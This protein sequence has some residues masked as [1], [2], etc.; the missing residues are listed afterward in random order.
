MPILYLAKVNLNSDIF[1]VYKKKLDIHTVMDLV[2]EKISN[3]HD[4][5]RYTNERY[6]DSLG[7]NIRYIR[8]SKYSFQEIDKKDH[9]IITGKIVRTFNRKTEKLNI[10]TQKMQNIDVI[11]NVSIY[12]YY[13]VY[14]EM[15]SFCERQTFGYNQFIEGFTELLNQCV[16]IYQFKIFLQKDK[17]VLEEKIKSL[18]TVYKVRAVLIPPNSNEEGLANLRGHLKYIS[19]IQDVNANKMLLEYNSLNMK[20]DS[21]IMNEIFEA[22]SIGYGDVTATGIDQDGHTQ[23]IR[24]SQDAAFTS[25]IEENIKEND[26]NREAKNLIQRFFEKRKHKAG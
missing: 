22:A 21:E 3:Q 26:Y 17:D 9:K 23:M 20:M 4:Y 1:D 18:K 12:F 14:N 16:G 2:Y 19:Q 8:E 25:V 11:E 10:E 5:K 6:S 7:N 15:I 13:D 24:S